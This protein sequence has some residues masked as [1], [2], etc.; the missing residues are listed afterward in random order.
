MTYAEVKP[1]IEGPACFTL[2]RAEV[3]MGVNIGG[4][5]LRFTIKCACGKI[6][7]ASHIMDD[8]SDAIMLQV[9]W[10]E[11]WRQL[12]IHERADMDVEP[13]LRDAI[14]LQLQE[15]ERAHA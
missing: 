7:Y 1:L 12:I 15:W 8:V 13:G 9:F 2:V 14:E 3:L 10:Q 4:G 6:V 11:F 5:L